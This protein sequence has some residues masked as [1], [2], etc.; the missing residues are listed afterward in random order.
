MSWVARFRMATVLLLVSFH[1]ATVHAREFNQHE[2][3]F[4]ALAHNKGPIASETE[5]GPDVTVAYQYLLN[6]Y[7]WGGL[8]VAGGAVANLSNGTSYLFSGLNTQFP[9]GE[10]PYFFELGFGLAIHDGDLTKKSN[11]RRELGSRVLFHTAMSVG[12]Q[13]SNDMTA[14]F[15]FDHISNGEILNDDDNRGLD[16]YGLRIGF[17]L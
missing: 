11:D 6:A 9:F 14:S 12:Y 10:S 16:T 1:A 8:F 13:F 7:D 3:R 5:D 4:G 2:L 17:A 15:Y